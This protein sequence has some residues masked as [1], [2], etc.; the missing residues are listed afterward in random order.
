MNNAELC[1]MALLRAGLWDYAA[2][3]P[4]AKGEIPWLDI[5]MI[6]QRQST[7][8]LVYHAALQLK[9]EASVP[10]AYL[11]GMQKFLMQTVNA[12]ASMNHALA[13]LVSALQSEGI[14]PLLLKGQSMAAWYSQPLLRQCGDIDLFVG[15]ESYEHA[16]RVAEKWV[17]A[18]SPAC[19]AD[20]HENDKHFSF[21][22]G[23]GLEVEIHRYTEVLEDDKRNQLWQT[24]SDEG[25]QSQLV[26]MTFDGVVVHTPNDDFN[27]LYVFHHMWHHVLGMGIGMRQLCDWMMFLHTHAGKLDLALLDKRLD[28]LGLKVVWK[29]FGCLT[30][31]S[32]GM[33]A[34]EMP[35][36]DASY[37]R[38]ARRLLRYLLDEGDNRD[39]KF[40]RS[41][42]VLFK[43][44]RTLSYL[45]SKLFRLCPVFPAITIRTFFRDLF[46][47]LGKWSH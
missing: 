38:R 16:C 22:M 42:N 17:I 6:A 45:F 34:E 10:V 15:E 13:T 27:V 9:G 24:I 20:T 40:G 30:V 7:R 37:E 3:L 23:G 46:A 47:G 39:F 21:S 33:P 36:Y 29:V 28:T 1:Y 32:L 43:K 4:V 8:G 19:V 26:P 25:T 41:T 44:M 14:E 5:A 11:P 35:F 31:Q 12:H 18:D 2:E